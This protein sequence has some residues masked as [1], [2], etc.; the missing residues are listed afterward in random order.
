MNYEG[1]FC[2]IVCNSK[3]LQMTHAHISWHVGKHSHEGISKTTHKEIYNETLSWKWQRI[4]TEA[5]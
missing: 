4:C 5:G 2:D 1:V 3:I